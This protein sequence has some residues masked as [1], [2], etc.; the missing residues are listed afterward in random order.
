MDQRKGREREREEERDM[1]NILKC[2]LLLSVESPS[3][4]NDRSEGG[5]EEGQE[6]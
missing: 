4:M 3:R 1:V 6:V 5:E 2:R